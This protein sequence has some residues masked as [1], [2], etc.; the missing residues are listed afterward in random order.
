MGPRER[1]P[2]PS[3]RPAPPA[4]RPRQPRG[5]A[6][7]SARPS[8]RPAV[9]PS[10]APAPA[11]QRARD[12]A[13]RARRRRCSAGP[14]ARTLGRH[15]ISSQNRPTRSFFHPSPSFLATTSPR[16][17]V[18]AAP[19]SLCLAAVPRRRGDLVS[20]F[21]SPPLSSS[22]L[23]RHG[24]GSA[25]PAQTP[26]SLLPCPSSP[27]VGRSRTAAL[28]PSSLPPERRRSSRADVAVVPHF[29]GEPRP[30]TPRPSRCAL[31]AHPAPRHG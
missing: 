14:R 16:N 31:A 10:S 26:S 29:A 8:A 1:G 19:R 17:A 30:Y 28:L 9:P 15:C 11:A 13:P 22:P 4:T 5:P 18:G 27:R 3:P 21:L 24:R 6:P 25:E 7:R 12:R 23:A 20:P 2:A